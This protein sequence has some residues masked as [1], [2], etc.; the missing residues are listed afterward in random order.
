ML[1]EGGSDMGSLALAKDREDEW[2]SIDGM[3]KKSRQSTFSLL[4][5]TRITIDNFNWIVR[6]ACKTR[7][8][9]G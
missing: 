3:P 1:G 4:L 8:L 7:T 6:F 5:P 9:R 2:D